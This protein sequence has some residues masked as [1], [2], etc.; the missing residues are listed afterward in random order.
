MRRKPITF[1]LIFHLNI[2]INVLAVFIVFFIVASQQLAFAITGQVLDQNGN[3]FAG[4]TVT[5][6]Y[7]STTVNQVTTAS[8]YSFADPC[9]FAMDGQPGGVALT[10][11]LTVPSGYFA[12]T[13]TSGNST[14]YR[15]EFLQ[16]GTGCGQTM[17]GGVWKHY[18]TLS[19]PATINFGISNAVPTAT[20]PPPPTPTPPLPTPTPTPPPVPDC[21]TTPINC[22][23]CAAPA[24]TCSNGNGTQTCTLSQTQTC[25]NVVVSQSCTLN[26]CNAG[27]V[28]TN[29]ACVVSNNTISGTVYNDANK[30]GTLDNGETG[31]QGITVSV[32]NGSGTQTTTTPA[33]GTYSFSVSP[34]A[35]NSTVTISG[36]PANWY[37]TTTTSQTVASNV[38]T[39]GLNFGIAQD[40]TVSGTVYNDTNQDGILDNGE[41]GYPGITVKLTNASG[42]QTITSAANGTYSFEVVPT[43][44]NATVTVSGIPAGWLNTSPTSQTVA[45]NVNTTGLNF[46]ITQENTISGNIFVDLNKDGIED[47]GESNYNYTTPP[48]TV[49]PTG[50]TVAEKWNRWFYIIPR[51]LPLG[52]HIP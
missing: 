5:E 33:N 36:I 16:P 24:N 37:N 35:G 1:N 22:S 6:T 40:N 14:S 18:L 28:C 39:T 17:V 29:Q 25:S 8:G 27:S 49:S 20:P 12:T 30:D 9:S 2:F 50:G 15:G 51:I 11:T 32:T 10:L 34:T 19:D 52:Q 3:S 43:A 42:S 41:I 48:I 21:T 38:N 45:S 13:A 26:N 44:G 4:A 31:Y 23:V 7:G 47:N 46:G